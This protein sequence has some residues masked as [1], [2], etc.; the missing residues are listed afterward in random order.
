M[1][2]AVGLAASPTMKRFS[3]LAASAST[4][5]AVGRPVGCAGTALEVGQ[6]GRLPAA[7][8]QH[9]GLRPSRAAR[10]K[11]ERLPVRREAR[12]RVVVA[13]RDLLGASPGHRDPPQ[14]RPVLAALDRPP[15]VDRGRA[16]GRDR[17][18]RDEGLPQDVLAGEALRHRRE[19][20]T[21][22]AGGAT[23]PGDPNPFNSVLRGRKGVRCTCL[24][25][26][27][28]RRCQAV[29]SGRRLGREGPAGR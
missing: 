29:E 10:E 3:P 18:M 17:Q 28:T 24:P 2:R 16:V 19:S 5:D 7:E 9:P 13:A 6:L 26:S 4:A 8:R 1:C 11:E 21:P 23:V 25:L 14:P 22:S 27:A 15:P 20:W 12:T